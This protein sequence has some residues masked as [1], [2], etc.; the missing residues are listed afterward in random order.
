MSAFFMLA[1]AIMYAGAAVSFALEGKAAWA[2]VAC[3]WGVGNAL[4]AWISR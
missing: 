3:S 4:L 2:I 1:I